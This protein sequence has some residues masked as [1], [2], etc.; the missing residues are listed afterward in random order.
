MSAVA[1]SM[2]RPAQGRVI[3][4]VCAAIAR[5]TSL[6]VT[7]VRVLAAIGVALLT[8]PFIVAYAAAA[9]ILP[10]DDGRMLIGGEPAD[11]RETL[12]GWLVVI[13]AAVLL[14][15]TP[16]IFGLGGHLDVFQFG[17]L[18]VAGCLIALSVSRSDGEATASP[19]AVAA[20]PAS[21]TAAVVAEPAVT[22]TEPAPEGTA[23]TEQMPPAPPA[24]PVPRPPKP[25]RRP[26]IFAPAFAGVIGL[27][28]LAAVVVSVFDIEITAVS[29]AVF[30][31]AL[32]VACCGAAFAAWGR[33]GT[34]PVLILGALL[35]V[36]A[37][38]A[39]IGRDELDRG[40]G[41]REAQPQTV[42][43]V[44]HG[45]ELGVG[46]LQ[47]DL[48]D[49]Q[50]PPGETTLPVHVGWGAAEIKVPNDLQV[51][52]TGDSVSGDVAATAPAAGKP[53]AGGGKQGKAAA[54]PRPP[55]LVVDG[56]VTAGSLEITRHQGSAGNG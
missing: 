9:L 17:I 37:S 4:G 27:T 8:T 6:D 7:L 32:A 19:P 33:R 16:G 13:P 52:S 42:A 31:G 24:S 5:R 23:E 34:V 14:I 49:V 15:A 18:V 21:P 41:Y 30:S 48:R 55:V 38:V 10:R 44:T 12:I 47:L 50:L 29:V 40:V 35:A 51:V 2:S 26:S 3:L 1:M 54:G 39:T 46:F 22:E 45:Y 25:D 43:E 11:R 53:G 56:D 36:V 28:G 20:A